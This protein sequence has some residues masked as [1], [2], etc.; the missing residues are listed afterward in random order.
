MDSGSAQRVR[1]PGPGR[2]P[3]RVRRKGLNVLGLLVQT[4]SGQPFGDYMEQ[5]VFEPLDMTHSHPT[6][7]GARGQYGGRLFAVVWLVLG[8]D[9]RARTHHRN[10]V[11]HHVR[12]GRGHRHE[13]I[14][15]TRER[16]ATA[17]SAGSSGVGVAMVINGND[18]SAPSR[19]KAVDT[20]VLRILHGQP[21][22][23]AVV[24]EDWLQRCSWAVS[25][26]LLV[27]ELLSRGGVGWRALRQRTSLDS[28]V[29]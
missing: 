27:A 29:P 13:R 8:P 17:V 11:H 9:R 25:L 24:Q 1:S 10:A 22:V 2:F 21:P 19:L 18:M 26:A 23:P 5:H 28:P 3:V 20:N 15:W 14:A 7:A 12:L 6:R 4:V 16:T